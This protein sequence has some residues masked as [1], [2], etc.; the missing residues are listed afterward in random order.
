MTEGIIEN[1]MAGGGGGKGGYLELYIPLAVFSVSFCV[2]KVLCSLIKEYR[3]NF[4]C[5]G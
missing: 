4:H 5:D 1:Y 3:T 2:L